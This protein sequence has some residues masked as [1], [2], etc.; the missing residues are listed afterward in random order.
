M[1]KITPRGMKQFESNL[2]KMINIDVESA[3]FAATKIEAKKATKIED[4]NLPDSLKS[5]ALQMR[6]L[7]T[8]WFSGFALQDIRPGVEIGE[9]GYRAVFSR[10]AL[11]TDENLLH[12]LGKTEGAVLAIELEVKEMNIRLSSLKAYDA[13]D[14]DLGPLGLEN[15]QI[16]AGSEKNPVKIRLPFF[17]AV[18]EKGQLQFEALKIEENFQLADIEMKYQK[19]ITPKIYIGYGRKRFELNPNQLEKT[20]NENMPQVLKTLQKGLGAF[21]S[22]QLPKLLN[23]KGLQSLQSRLEE[24]YRIAPPGADSKKATDPFIWGLQLEKILQQN[25]VAVRLKAYV[26]DPKNPKSQPDPESASRGPVQNHSLEADQYDMALSIDRGFVNR[27]LQLSFERGLFDKVQTGASASDALYLTAAPKVDFVEMPSDATKV[28]GEAFLK[29]RVQSRVGKGKVSGVKT[30]AIND[31][32]EFAFDLI[33]KLRR[34]PRTNKIEIIFN[35]ID[36]KSIWLNPKDIK[37]IGSFIS[38][39]GMAD[40]KAQIGASLKEIASQWKVKEQK[41]PGSLTMFKDLGDLKTEINDMI[42]DS[43][44]YLI[45]YLNYRPTLRTSLGKGREP[46]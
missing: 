25:G 12:Q 15:V 4:L 32:F 26:E 23:E 7:L 2:S 40:P 30:L 38:M 5:L 17:V 27:F 43:N 34:I 16:K 1:I 37:P 18:N 20:F 39:L 9:S 3:N 14:K 45:L 11:V 22:E 13:D 6:S 29:I 21:A 8:N 31:Q 41:M 42:L 28:Q 36:E 24:T 46:L 19:L 33:A 35:D 10:F 44:G